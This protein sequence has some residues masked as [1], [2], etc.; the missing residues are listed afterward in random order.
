MKPL[1]FR[2]KAKCI[3]INNSHIHMAKGGKVCKFPSKETKQFQVAIQKKFK[4]R[5]PDHKPVECKLQVR[6][7]FHLTRHTKRD[8]DNLAKIPLDA[9]NGLVWKDDS[10][11]YKLALEK[12]EGKE[13]SVQF[14]IKKFHEL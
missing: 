3:S 14:F 10:L 6:M 8:V 9:L 13:D 11:V 2:I 5:Y 7:K 1:R 4:E 12:F